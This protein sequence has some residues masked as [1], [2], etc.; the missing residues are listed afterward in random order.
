MIRSMTGYGRAEARSASGT[1]SIEMRSVNNRFLDVQVKLPRSLAAIEQRVRKAVQARF[2]RG[3]IDVFINH[4]GSDAQASRLVLDID[5]AGQYV[6]IMREMK[7]RFDLPGEVDLALV[8]AL[9]D[10]IGRE[11]VTEDLDQIW[12]SLAG[13]LEG[14]MQGLRA[15]RDRE[16]QALGEDISA[17]LETIDR[18]ADDIRD[19]VPET[20]KHARARMTASIEK[21]LK[22]PPEPDRIAQEIA[23]LADRTDV[24]EELTRL[25]SHVG[26]FR[27]FLLAAGAEAEPVGRK[28]DFLLQEIGRE[29][30]TIASKALDADISLMVVT[31][32]AEIEKIREQVQNVE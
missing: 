22:E 12:A 6:G 23:F 10:I 30:N 7:S 18:L 29:V 25:G 19:R 13:G 2:S 3:R 8:S 17:R 27:D 5:R 24:S 15:M 16:G 26:Q 4:G 21:L 32:K 14:A 20:I 31:I 11:E 1:F 9:P 28:L